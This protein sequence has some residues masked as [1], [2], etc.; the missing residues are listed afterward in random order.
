MATAAK[1]PKLDD[2]CNI[3]LPACP[4]GI[5]C[6]RKNP[7]HLKEYSHTKD[8]VKDSCS[9]KLENSKLPPCKYGSNCY[10]TNLLHFAEFSHPF[11][12]TPIKSGSD[13]EEYD[14]D[15]DDEESSSVII[16]S[17]LSVN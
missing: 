9:T 17:I 11:G 7:E 13:T 4:Y 14:S 15:E 3:S 16:G 8:Y 10:R 6:Y 1:K 2:S 12:S 5:K